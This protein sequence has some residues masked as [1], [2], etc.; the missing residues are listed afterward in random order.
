MF[1]LFPCNSVQLDKAVCVRLPFLTNEIGHKHMQNLWH[2]QLLLWSINH[3]GTNL[4]FQNQH[5][6]RS[7]R[8]ASQKSPS[9]VGRVREFMASSSPRLSLT[10]PTPH[11]HQLRSVFRVLICPR[12]AA[13]GESGDLGL[14]RA[15]SCSNPQ[16]RV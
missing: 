12:Q 1:G 6:S 11:R 13:T 10:G 8:T 9:G 14:V 16:M 2:T 3:V 4:H 15:Q 7:G 5:D